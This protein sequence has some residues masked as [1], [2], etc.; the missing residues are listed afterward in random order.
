MIVAFMSI[1]VAAAVSSATSKITRISS[2]V[3]APVVATAVKK[4]P[5]IRIHHDWRRHENR[6]RGHF[7]IDLR[8]SHHDLAVTCGD[9]ARAS[10][11]HR[12]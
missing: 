6:R 5:G 1:M 4:E 10:Q 2:A 12:H 11:Q 9:E 7:N 8:R 3:I